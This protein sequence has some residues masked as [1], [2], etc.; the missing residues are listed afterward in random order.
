MQYCW[1]LV[2]LH[3]V[4]LV[5]LNGD[6]VLNGGF[7]LGWVVISRNATV[8]GAATVTFQLWKVTCMNRECTWLVW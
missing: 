3:I 2:A 7:V 5:D 8:S 6:R 4:K 1:V